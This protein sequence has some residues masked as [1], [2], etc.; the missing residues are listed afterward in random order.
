M[1]T[2][3]LALAI[4]PCIAHADVTPVFTPFKAQAPV[5]PPPTTY[6]FEAI[7]D[8]YSRGAAIGVSAFWKRF[9][10]K[11]KYV[12]V[13]FFAGL[14]KRQTP[15]GALLVKHTWQIADNFAVTYGPAF[16]YSQA[17]TP[18][19]TVFVGVTLK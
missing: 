5:L 16:Q 14:D 10:K 9:S 3:I 18:H 2:F 11:D 13:Y 15:V 19:L 8:R 17:K 4:L 12:D 7:Y 6:E 1:K